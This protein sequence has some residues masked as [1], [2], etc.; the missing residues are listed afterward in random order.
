MDEEQQRKHEEAWERYVAA[1][2]RDLGHRRRN[3]LLA[4]LQGVPL[5]GMFSPLT[6]H[7]DDLIHVAKDPVLPGLE[8]LYQGMLRSVEML[9]RV[10]VLG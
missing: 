10:F 1:E 3:G 5:S 8:G 4:G 2:R 9:G 7:H 6:R